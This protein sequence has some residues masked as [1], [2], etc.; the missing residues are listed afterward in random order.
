MPPQVSLLT[1]QDGDGEGHGHD[2]GN[3]RSEARYHTP[4]KLHSSHF[5]GNSRGG[6]GGR[7]A[8][9]ARCCSPCVRRLSFSWACSSLLVLVAG[10]GRPRLNFLPPCAPESGRPCLPPPH[11]CYAPHVPPAL[12]GFPRLAHCKESF[13]FFFLF[14]RKNQFFFLPTA[15]NPFS[16]RNRKNPR[17]LRGFVNRPLPTPGPLLEARHV[18]SR[19]VDSVA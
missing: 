16:L 11:T 19:L 7:Q 8:I 4:R 2:E 1:D 9:V 17:S 13:V 15:K 5:L 10:V 3:P 6:R 14:L 12:D 18:G